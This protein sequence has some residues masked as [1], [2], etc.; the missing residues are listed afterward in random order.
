MGH[1]PALK[2][3]LVL[4]AN[5]QLLTPRGMPSGYGHPLTGG[6]S[7]NPLAHNSI[8]ADDTDQWGRTEGKLIAFEAA[9]RVKLMRAVDNGA[10]GDIALDRTLFLTDGYV[11]DLSGAYA[12]SGRHRYDLCYRS[13]GELS[14]PLPFEGREEPLGVGYGYQYLT[15]V[16]SKRTDETWSA[17]W[18]QAE[19]SAVRLT[20]V[21]GPETEVIACTSPSNTDR[22]DDVNALNCPSVSA[23]DGVRRGVEPY[24]EKPFLSQ[25]V[26]LPVKGEGN[27][28]D[29]AG[30]VGVE[31][32]EMVQRPRSVSWLLTPLG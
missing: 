4:Y 32:I 28:S 12:E 9:P 23:E 30:G 11:V 27:G 14:C 20:V 29:Q 31:V 1:A 22:D 26:S 6:W 21:G 15:D 13:F 24:R 25:I 5:R 16:R 3:G 18:R 8:T 19:D 7:R 2:F 17:D 10:Y